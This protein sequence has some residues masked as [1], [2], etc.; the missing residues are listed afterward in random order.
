MTWTFDYPLL[1]PRLALRP[2]TLDDLD[3][4]V[5]FH[6]DPEVTRYIPWPVRTREQTLEALRAKLPRTSAS[7]PGDWIV[8]A[9][10]EREGGT[11]IGEVLLK[12]E[13]GEGR[14]E[15]GY[16]FRTDRHGQGLAR[17]AVTGLLDAARDRLGVTDVGAVVEPGN[18]ASIGLL[19]RLGFRPSG[20]GA[21]G[22]LGF[23]RVTTGAGDAVPDAAGTGHTGVD[24]AEPGDAPA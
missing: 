9:V 22:L 17:E 24:D 12:R 4:L 13:E 7:A 20:T 5:V 19:T 14:A 21:E 10:A 18:A 23:R 1:T 2:H 3:D 15:V 6:G 11:V 16:A 8:L